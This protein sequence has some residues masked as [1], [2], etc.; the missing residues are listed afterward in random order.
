MRVMRHLTF[1]AY[2]SDYDAWFINNREVLESELKLLAYILGEPGKTLSIGC[3]SGI[4]EFMLKQTFG[5][6][7]THGIEPSAGMAAIARKRGMEVLEA[8]A[9]EADF[10]VEKYDTLLFNGTPS[11]IDD[12]EKA[13]RKASAALK[14]G[15]HI[16]V[17]DVPKESGYG[18]LYNLA[19]TLG[20]WDHELLKG[21]EPRDPYPIEFVKAANWR[22]TAEK[23]ELLEKCGFTDQQYAQTLT[24]HPHFSGLQVEEPVEGYHR[25]DYV[26]IKARK[27]RD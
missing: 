26:A 2:A 6:E 9:E 1:D 22:T 21:T 19:K 16:V 4:F 17:L 8:T 3:G 15:G 23:I 18:V 5:V 7:I 10:G 13:F 24:T 20:S 27:I 25:G 12:L 11:Y 14:P